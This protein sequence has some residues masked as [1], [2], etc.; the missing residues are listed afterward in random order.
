MTAAV[1]HHDGDYGL[2]VLTLPE[3]TLSVPAIDSPP[4]T[5][6]RVR[7]RAA[8]V[9]LALDRPGDISANNVLAAAVSEIRPRESGPFADIQLVSGGQHLVARIT[10]RSLERLGLTP[11]RPVYAVI[12]TVQI[13]G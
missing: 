5:S 7:V 11:G 13:E 6:V 1:D 4:G 2:T 9:M 8:D 3:G 12:K 10:R